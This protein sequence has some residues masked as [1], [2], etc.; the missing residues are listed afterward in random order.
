LQLPDYFLKR[1]VAEV[2]NTIAFER[3][4]TNCVERNTAAE[5][6]Y[7]LTAPKWQFL[8]YLCETKNILLHGSSNPAILEFEP[9]QSNDV[10][11]FGNCRAVYAASD[12]I[13][14][15][16]FAIVNRKRITSLVN[17]CFQVLNGNS[18]VSETYYYFSVNQDALPYYPWQNGTIYLLPRDS[19]KQEAVRQYHGLNVEMAHWASPVA[20]KPLATFSVTPDDFPFLTQVNGHNPQL[21]SERASHNPDGFP[22]R[23]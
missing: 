21:L 22:W 4:F 2:E 11:E 8:C 15:L 3:L 10:N 9:R 12:G 16:Y 13:W 23:E 17:G 1:P 6:S 19:F 14:P 18:S 7:Q 20:V 5:I